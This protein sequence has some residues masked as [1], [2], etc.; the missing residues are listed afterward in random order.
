MGDMIALETAAA[1]VQQELAA[2]FPGRRVL[3]IWMYGSRARDA[4]RPDSDIDLAVLCDA[5][6]DP[7][8]LFDASGRLA[9]RLGS[10]VDLVDL[11]RAGGLLRVEAT[12]RGKPLT[13]PTTEADLFTTHALSDHA[14]F[15]P[16]RRAATR[17]FEERYRGR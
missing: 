1:I 5:Q 9:A 15:A 17:A 14:A 3:G 7:V 4:H 12:H 2:S 6:L 13:P 10:P 11:R 8:D 16:N